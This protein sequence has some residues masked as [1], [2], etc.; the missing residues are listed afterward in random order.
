MSRLEKINKLLVEYY[1]SEDPFEQTDLA[2]GIIQGHV[3]FLIE[4]SKRADKNA[5]DLQEM[6][7]QLASEQKR[8]EHYQQILK[9]AHHFIELVWTNPAVS[10][11]EV[12]AAIQSLMADALKGE[13]K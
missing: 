5:E 12:C 6:D 10:K 3:G 9:R 2:I 13:T 7:Q 11:D 4:E 1:G 8:I